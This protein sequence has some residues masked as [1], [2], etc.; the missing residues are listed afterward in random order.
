V[1]YANTKAAILVHALAAGAAL[2]VPITDV[3]IGFALPTGRCVRIYWGGETEPRHMGANRT[4][5][6]ELIGQRTIIGAFW[7]VTTLSTDQAAVIDAEMAA[8]AHELRTR[9]D[10]D[11][12]LGGTQSDISLDLGTPDFVTIGSARFLAVFW[13]VIGDYFEYTLGA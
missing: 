13:D 11:A 10:G 9:L 2:T 8:L 3:A 12:Q 1:A 7:P 6:S 4:L 5:T